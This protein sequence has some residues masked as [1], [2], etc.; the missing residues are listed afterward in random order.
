MRILLSL[1]L[2]RTPVA[3]AE[4]NPPQ[5]APTHRTAAVALRHITPGIEMLL[6]GQ[7]ASLRGKR[8]ALLT[9]HTGV[10]RSGTSSIELLRAHRD[11]NLVALFSPEHGVRGQAQAGEK[12]ASGI[13]PVSGLPIRSLYGETNIAFRRDLHSVHYNF[14]WHRHYFSRK[15]PFFRTRNYLLPESIRRCDSRFRKFEKGYT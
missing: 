3:A 5:P 6:A 15:R 8:T 10:D 1:L 12:V 14:A 7:T 2:H 4:T 13:D 9:N 11:I